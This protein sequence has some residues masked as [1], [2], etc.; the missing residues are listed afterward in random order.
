MKNNDN[1]IICYFIIIMYYILYVKK[2][3]YI[4]NNVP[5][6][7]KIIFNECVRKSYVK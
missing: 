5:L 6:L 2:Y 3:I 4:K 7:S 1:D